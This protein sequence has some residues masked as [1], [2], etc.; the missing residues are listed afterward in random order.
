M[1]LYIFAEYEEIELLDRNANIKFI[2]EETI[3]NEFKKIQKI[4]FYKYKNKKFA[5]AISGVGKVNSSLFLCYLLS[6]YK[7]K[8]VI[9]IGPAGS[10]EREKIA[11]S[12]LIEKAYYGDVDLTSLPNYEIGMLPNLKKYFY[13][14]NNLNKIINKKLNLDFRVIATQDKFNTNYQG[15]LKSKSLYDMECASFAHTALFFN[16]PFS[17]IKVISDNSNLSQYKNNNLI[18]KSKIY[19]IFLNLIGEL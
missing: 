14:S 16:I 11:N 18:W 3:D 7:F 5:V 13:T 8:N 9:N 15:D 10:N 6:K 2:K 4:T 1:N 12:F 19:N 17:A